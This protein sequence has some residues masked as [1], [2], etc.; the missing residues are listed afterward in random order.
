VSEGDRPQEPAPGPAAGPT[1]P[2]DESIQA[3]GQAGKESLAASRDALKALRALFSADLALA[4]SAMGRALAWTGVAV[5]FGASTWLLATAASVAV[6]QRM[7]LSWLSSLCIAALF[8]LVV[9]ALAAWRTS[10]FFDHMGLH[11]TRRQLARMGLFDEADEDDEDKPA[12]GAPP[13]GPQ[14]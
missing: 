3:I 7:G 2:L 8:N 5:V 10:R 13:P 4:R 6:M 1:P 9:T 14:A 12:P 11:A